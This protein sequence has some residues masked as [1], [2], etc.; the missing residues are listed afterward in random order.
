MFEGCAG[1]K[2]AGR[3]GVARRQ[4][5]PAQR[6]QRARGGMPCLLCLISHHAAACRASAPAHSLPLDA[7]VVGQ[8]LLDALR[9]GGHPR[10]H[11]GGAGGARRLARAARD[12]AG[13]HPGHAA[14]AP[15]GNGLQSGLRQ[16]RGQ[17][18]VSIMRR[19]GGSGGQTPSFLGCCT[20]AAVPR[21]AFKAALEARHHS[22][23]ANPLP[24]HHDGGARPHGGGGVG[25]GAARGGAVGAAVCRGAAAAARGAPAAV[26]GGAGREGRGNRIGGVCARLPKC[27]S[28]PV[29][30]MQARGSC[31]PHPSLPPLP[32]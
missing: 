4:G 3:R 19:Q 12:T 22:Q 29:A 27:K 13:V 20:P 31:A 18:H 9:P 11:A 2:G 24:T 6:S 15:V 5:R 14:K 23:P 30:G 17:R 32:P 8:Q 10:R 28:I 25:H 21:D 16:G 26:G 7:S 1:V